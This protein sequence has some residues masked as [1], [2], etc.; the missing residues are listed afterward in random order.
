M[1]AGAEVEYSTQDIQQARAYFDKLSPEQSEKLVN[2]LIAGLPGA[3][4]H[5]TLEDFRALLR[6]YAEI[7]EAKLREHLGHFLPEVITV[8]E[9]AGVR[10]AIST[11]TTRQ[12]AAGPAAYFVHRRRRAMTA[13]RCT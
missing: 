12:G 2:T 7:D 11:R 6:T 5:Y 13:G 9:E 4:E 3:E 10:M 8:A 1:C